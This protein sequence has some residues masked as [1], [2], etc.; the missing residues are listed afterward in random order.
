[1]SLKRRLLSTLTVVGIVG[2]FAVVSFAQDSTTPAAP[3]KKADKPFKGQFG[4][5]GMG[6]VPGR[7]GFA[8][9]AQR[10][11]GPFAF[12]RGLGLTDAQ[13]EQIRTIVQTN[14]PDPTLMQELRTIMQARRAGTITDAQKARAQEIRQ[15]LQQLRRSTLQ[16]IIGVLTP[17]QK[18]ILE[19]RRHQQQ[20]R[21]QQW[22][23]LLNPGG[24]DKP[25]PTPDKPTSN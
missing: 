21:M 2:A 23:N 18:A 6:R 9:G 13:K 7:G 11:R 10:A 19:K 15:H 4:A 22:K 24:P 12:L 14:R 8:G 1:M 17:E 16:Q 3:E 5:P 25:A 20:Q